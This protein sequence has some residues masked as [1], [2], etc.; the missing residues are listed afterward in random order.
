MIITRWTDQ[1]LDQLADDVDN[2]RGS[3]A[4]LRATAE[5]MLQT[6]TQHQ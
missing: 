1:R 3:V 2:L 4:D 6:Q 5:I